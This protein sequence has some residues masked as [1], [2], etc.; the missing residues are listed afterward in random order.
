MPKISPVSSE[1]QLADTIA[2][3]CSGGIG[4]YEAAPKK[5]GTTG[6]SNQTVL[7]FI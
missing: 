2:P 1:I 4:M 6:F 7:Q 5:P 3:V